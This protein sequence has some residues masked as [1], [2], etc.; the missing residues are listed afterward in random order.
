M[1]SDEH[2]ETV[3]RAAIRVFIDWCESNYNR[4]LGS[5]AVA[6]PKSIPAVIHNLMHLMPL[7]VLADPMVTSR[8]SP[9]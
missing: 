2:P 7:F 4:Y 6:G 8:G 9:S 5:E 3:Y 1:N